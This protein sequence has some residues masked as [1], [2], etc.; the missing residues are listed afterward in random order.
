MC[1]TTLR[2]SKKSC[3]HWGL[4]HWGLEQEGLEQE[5]TA[6]QQEQLQDDD[7]RA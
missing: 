3:E 2:S 7:D 5:T 4:E 6:T 1:L